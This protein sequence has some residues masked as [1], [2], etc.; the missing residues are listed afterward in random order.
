MEPKKVVRY[1]SQKTG[2][3]VSESYAMLHPE[4]T[5]IENIENHKKVN[6]ESVKNDDKVSSV[7]GVGRLP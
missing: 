6:I 4:N 2:K 1:R 5:S 7:G 3:Y